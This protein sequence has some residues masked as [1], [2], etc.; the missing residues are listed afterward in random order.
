MEI[1]KELKK[2]YLNLQQSDGV[3]NAVLAE[4]EN[5][6]KVKLPSDFCEIASFYSGGYLGGIS[7]YSF[8]NNDGSTNI[9]EETVRLRDTINLPLRYVVLAE[10]PESIIV[11]DTENIP[12]IIWCDAV[13]VTKLND[14]SFISKPNEWNSYA[15]YFA[16]LIEDEEDDI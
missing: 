7:N 15:E 10:P 4:I 9:I 11:M 6:L 13:E 1:I 12:S 5:E 3:S 2:R 8:S 16:Q 14:K